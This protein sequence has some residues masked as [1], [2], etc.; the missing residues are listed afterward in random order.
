MQGII[1]VLNCFSGA[2]FL[3][4]GLTHLVPHV[5]EYQA[6]ARP[7]MDYPLGLALVV[8]GF[9]L[10]LCIEQI[11]FDVHGAAAERRAGAGEGYS[12]L[13]STLS[14]GVRFQEP[15]FTEAALVVH[16]VLE[17]LV[18]GFAVRSSDAL[19]RLCFWAH[20]RVSTEPRVVRAVR[21][22]PRLV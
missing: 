3:T 9:L 14:L 18:L 15:L 22:P 2:V 19:P 6:L 20:L 10:I 11:V 8:V 13:H 21:A 12:L 5:I 1:S 7:S 4:V 16:A 17:A